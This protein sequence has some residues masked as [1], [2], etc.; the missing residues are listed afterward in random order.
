[1]PAYIL[2][3]VDE[4]RDPDAMNQYVE[5]IAPFIAQHGGRYIFV[6]GEVHAI[7]GELQPAVLAAVEFDDMDRLRAFW[8][9]PENA[10]VKLLRHRGSRGNVL[11]V[12]APSPA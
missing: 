6:S 1:M 5:Q 4:V 7:E 9:S 3:I 8:E 11:F 2:G 10:A 12:N